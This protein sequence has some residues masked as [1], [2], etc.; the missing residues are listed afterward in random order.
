MQPSSPVA[1][2]RARPRHL[3]LL[4]GSVL[5]VASVATLR[6]HYRLSMVIGTSMRPTLAAGDLLLIDRQAYASRPPARGDLVLVRRGT[7]FLVKRVVGLPGERVEV[8]QGAVWIDGRRGPGEERRCGSL[9]IRSGLMRSGRYALLGDNRGAGGD[10]PVHVIASADQ[11]AG[12]VAWAW[13]G[14]RSLLELEWPGAYPVQ[15]AG[16]TAPAPNQ[17]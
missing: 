17:S 2:R 3:A 6:S 9:Q 4:L 12:K 8:R 15:S 7:E 11:F 5:L 13:H 16:G 10:E 1:A 14:L